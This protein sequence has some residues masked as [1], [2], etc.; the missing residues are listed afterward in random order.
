MQS[1][2]LLAEFNRRG[3]KH[4]IIQRDADAAVVELEYGEN[5]VAFQFTWEQAKGEP[6]TKN[7][8]GEIKANYATPRARMQMLWARC[9]ADGVRVV[10]PQVGA[11]NYTP[12]ELSGVSPEHTVEDAEFVSYES[13]KSAI[14]NAAELEQPASAGGGPT[15]S[16]AAGNDRGNIVSAGSTG[17]QEAPAET[18]PFDTSTVAGNQVEKLSPGQLQQIGELRN[19]LAKFVPDITASW[20]ATLSKNFN[21]DSARDLTS[22]QAGLLIQRLEQKVKHFEGSEEFADQALAPGK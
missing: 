6:F 13:G 9:V 8:K 1:H 11:G 17:A 2:Y 10:M 20:K 21:G 15:D 22:E 16:G 7:K 4:R 18:A 12:E 5:R 19:K 14:D 3:G